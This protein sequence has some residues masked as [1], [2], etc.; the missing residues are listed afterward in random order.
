VSKLE[1]RREQI[2]GHRRRANALERRLPWDRASL[3]RAAQ[4]GLQD[5]AP[6]AALLSIH[7]RVEGTTP[8]AW[9]DPAYVQ[10]WGPRFSVYVV[11]EKDRALF[12]LSRLSDT[13]GD[14]R[15]ARELADRLHA[16]LRG[17]RLPY[18]D[19]AQ[20][21]GLPNHNVLRYVA[22]T[23]TLLMRW[24]GARRPLVWTV[25][26]PDIE[27]IAARLELARRYVHMFGPTTA[28]A[29][30]KWAGIGG[31]DGQRAFAALA[32]DLTPARSPVGEGVILTGDEA[33]FRTDPS[34]SDGVRLL[35]SGDAY[36]LLWG[37]DRDLLVP[38]TGHRDMLW[39]PRVWPGALLVSGEIAGTWR[40]AG[41]NLDV[42]TWRRLS[43]TERHAVEAEAAAL[44][45]PGL[46]RPVTVRWVPG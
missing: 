6:R 21:L 38:D 31:A 44:P 16:Y 13:P 46:D 33:S 42:E 4:V 40:R 30:A 39:T 24:E 9:E 25:E 10:V 11:A 29:F 19:V 5:S 1:L 27:P 17:R 23:G 12:T 15:F 14:L 26:A 28:A 7:A 32:G 37:A 35:P 2:L 43:P 8:T 45:L 34:P 3:E 41:S 22:P 36:W 18:D 20:A